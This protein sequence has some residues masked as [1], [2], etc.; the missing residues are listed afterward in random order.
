MFDLI[1]VVLVVASFALALG[2]ANLCAHVLSPFT[3]P[4]DAS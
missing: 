2:Y 3:G 1:I 4:D